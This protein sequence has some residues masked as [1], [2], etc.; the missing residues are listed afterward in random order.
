MGK[1]TTE[2]TEYLENSVIHEKVSL[3]KIDHSTAGA[4]YLYENFYG[5]NGY[6]KF[7]VEIVGMAILSH[8]SGLQNFVQIDVSTSDYIRRVVEKDLPY[9]EEVKENFEAIAGNITRVKN[10]F[11]E[12][13]QEFIVF[14]KK[15]QSMKPPFVYMNY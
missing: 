7:V 10:L 9:Y 12:A 8:H 1:F 15:I 14:T 2:F 3:T 13:V 6:E 4:K 11:G 5:E